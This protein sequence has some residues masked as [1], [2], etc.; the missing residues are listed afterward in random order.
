[1]K[2]RDA[3]G[4]GPNGCLIR[5]ARG[6]FR[7][8]PNIVRVG[9][10]AQ[11][12]REFT[13]CCCR[14]FSGASQSF[15][16]GNKSISFAIYPAKATSSCQLTINPTGI[17]TMLTKTK[18]L[19]SIAIVLGTSPAGRASAEHLSHRHQHPAAGRQLSPIGPGWTAH[20]STS[21]PDDPRSYQGPGHVIAGWEI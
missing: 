8:E 21:L 17:T 9:S 14:T 12:I 10:A 5:R 19:L 4:T 13:L 20:G 2:D 15:A 3:V 6:L 18:M 16:S 7:R 11:P 1:M